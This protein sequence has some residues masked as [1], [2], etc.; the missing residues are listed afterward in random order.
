[1]IS[2]MKKRTKEDIL[3]YEKIVLWGA[4]YACP[5]TIEC[6]GAERI[7]G[8][9][10]NDSE[11]W[12][13]QIKGIPVLSPDEE[14][15]RFVEDSA[16]VISANGYE[17]EIAQGIIGRGISPD[18]IFCAT[19]KIT[20]ECRYR[21]DII[22]EH[23]DQINDVCCRLADRESK[24]F[25]MRFIEACYTRNPLLF[26]DN[27]R[28]KKAYEY[29]TDLAAVGVKEGD[30]ILDCG[31]YDGDTARIFLQK[32]NNNCI[33]HCFEPVVENCN[34]I[35]RWI[36]KDNLKN[37]FAHNVGVGELPHKDFVY[38][39]EAVTMMGAVGDN[40]FN[41]ENPVVSEIQVEALD[42]MA[43]N[44]D[45]SYIKMDIEGAEMSAL[46]GAKSVIAKCRP[47]MLLSGYHRITDMWEIPEFIYQLVPDY[48]VFLGH[49]PHVPYE[50][51]FIFVM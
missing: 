41:A 49:Q 10:D 24:E 42:N 33:V 14:I 7:N 27:P 39:T 21:P 13:K 6:L 50:P 51:E 4:G 38:S 47:Q 1:M 31:A 2:G 11:K 26:R 3:A 44:L 5:A 45:V 37:V 20:E 48:K 36:E 9:F 23:W 40:R 34:E 30:I 35:Q 32:T 17:Y 18:R 12:G 22:E 29:K 8:V 19:N 15:A 16:F 25:Y 28:C 46:R 43:A